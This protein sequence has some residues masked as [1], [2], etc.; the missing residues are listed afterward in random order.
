M[1]P[2]DT[3]VPPW[4]QGLHCPIQVSAKLCLPIP[5]YSFTFKFVPLFLMFAVA[6]HGLLL[7]PIASR[8]LCRHFSKGLRNVF[9]FFFQKCFRYALTFSKHSEKMQTGVWL[10]GRRGRSPVPGDVMRKVLVGHQEVLLAVPGT[11]QQTPGKSPSR[12]FWE[13]GGLICEGRLPSKVTAAS[14]PPLCSLT[15]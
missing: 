5:C 6:S 1:T 8:I 11:G 14:L 13:V 3:S 7:L 2:L 9:F 4:G 12:R 10:G 15:T